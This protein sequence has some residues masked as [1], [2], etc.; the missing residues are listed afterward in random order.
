MLECEVKCQWVIAMQHKEYRLIIVFSY[1]EDVNSVI[2]NGV[3][4]T[5]F[6]VNLEKSLVFSVVSTHTD[7]KWGPSSI[8]AVSELV[9]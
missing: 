2:F 4:L 5:H 8:S 6:I 9:S 3:K 7:Y 1:Y